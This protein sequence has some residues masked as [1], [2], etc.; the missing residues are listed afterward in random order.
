MTECDDHPSSMSNENKLVGWI[1]D[2]VNH[3]KTT[4]ALECLPATHNIET[5]VIPPESTERVRLRLRYKNSII[6]ESKIY[7]VDLVCSYVEDC[8]RI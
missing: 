3:T 4:Q 1:D 6:I 8:V 5:D 7:Y 2:S